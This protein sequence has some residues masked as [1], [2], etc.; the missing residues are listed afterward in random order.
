[1]PIDPDTLQLIQRQALPL[2]ES[3]RPHQRILIWGR[4]SWVHGWPMSWALARL[5]TWIPIPHV[6]VQ[7]SMVCRF[8]GRIGFW[9]SWALTR[10]GYRSS[11]TQEA[12]VIGWKNEVN[13]HR[14]Y[15]LAFPGG[16][17]CQVLV[18]PLTIN[19]LRPLGIDGRRCFGSGLGRSAI[20]QFGVGLFGSAEC[21]DDRCDTP[22]G[23]PEPDDWA[24]VYDRLVAL[25]P[26][27]WG[28][29]KMHR[30]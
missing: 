13:G 27:E 7:P 8:G 17:L 10:F 9:S 21:V 19:F 29:N 3:V 12:F 26:E 24:V 16:K 11:L 23:M 14:D 6:K 1:M 2:I 20:A 18:T 28:R 30:V 25:A 5:V 22:Y 4:A 15:V